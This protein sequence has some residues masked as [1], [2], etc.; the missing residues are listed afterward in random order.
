MYPLN[1]L[2]ENNH[3]CG[4][5]DPLKFIDKLGNRKHIVLYY[6]NK[7]YSKKIQFRFIRNGLLKGETCIFTTHGDDITLIEN[8]MINN[9]INVENYYNRG[10]L[11]IFKI[12]HVMKHPEGELKGTEEIMDT[13]FSGM[14]PPFRLVARMIDTI[15]T[16]EQIRANLAIEHYY[17]SKFDQFNGLILCPY[18]VSQ[19]PTNTNGKWVETILD[20]HHS[21][22]FI[23]EKA[24]EGIALEI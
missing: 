23:T 15:N 21:A 5:N 12:P 9:D 24:A 19:N 20:N 8:E 16:E 2:K 3:E 22:I 11:R 13:M 4:F 18:D 1:L 14:T 17:H 7:E 10:L 6:E